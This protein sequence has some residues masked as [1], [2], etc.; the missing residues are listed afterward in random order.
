MEVYKDITG[1]EGRYCVSTYGNVKALANRNAGNAT[2][3]SDILLKHDVTNINSEGNG[4]SRVTLSNSGKTTRMAVHR[5]VALAFIP[6]PYN[7]PVVNHI[8]NNPTNNHVT[9]LEW[10]T[11][12]ENAQ[13]S[14]KQGRL[15]RS[16][17]SKAKQSETVI[18]K[19]YSKY[20]KY[21]GSSMNGRTLISI[22]RRS[23]NSGGSRV[24]GHFTCAKCGGHTA[25]ELNSVLKKVDRER[26]LYC[27]KCSKA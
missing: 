18:Q 26:P 7:K 19:T 27:R 11:S 15:I 6:N 1:Y 21:L 24:V 16:T 3:N 10:V 22:E 23:K 4:Y 2:R 12:K 8:D 5:L 9:N 20:S 13:H 14:S 25:C 17:A